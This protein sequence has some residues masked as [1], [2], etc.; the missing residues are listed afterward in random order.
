M[1]KQTIQDGHQFAQN[2]RAL[3][4]YEV[5]ERH[6]AGI[7]L[8]GSEVKAIRDG[9]VSR[10]GIGVRI[11]DDRVARRLGVKGGVLIH[12]VVPNKPAAR[13]GLRPTQVDEDGR[14]ARLGDVIIAFD[15]QPLRTT[16]DLHRQLEKHRVGDR[17]TL[18]VLRDEERVEVELTLDEL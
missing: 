5:L 6:E 10:P 17:V 8:M 4:E 12:Q 11:V 14:V 1:T 2:R 9:K 16:D 7:E 13:A 3:F 15:G 18:T